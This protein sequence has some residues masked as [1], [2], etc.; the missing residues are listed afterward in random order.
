MWL[1]LPQTRPT[2]W[3]TPSSQR[4]SITY[5]QTQVLLLREKQAPSQSCCGHGSCNGESYQRCYSHSPPS[6]PQ[7][8]MGGWCRGRPGV[9][10]TPPAAWLFHRKEPRGREAALP[11]PPLHC[12][13]HSQAGGCGGSSSPHRLPLSQWG[14]PPKEERNSSKGQAEQEDALS[15]FGRGVEPSTTLQ[16]YLL[17]PNQGALQ[18]SALP[19]SSA[20]RAFFFF[21]SLYLKNPKTTSQAPS[22]SPAQKLSYA[23]QLRAGSRG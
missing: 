16:P 11:P 1:L 8:Q 17:T 12:K 14:C 18:G 4:V 3:F 20:R 22:S 19:P 23:S 13:H 6:P 2:S 5:S 15:G 7:R 21:Y 9:I 10:Y